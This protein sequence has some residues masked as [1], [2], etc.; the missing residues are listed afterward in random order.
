MVRRD[1][2]TWHRTRAKYFFCQLPNFASLAHDIAASNRYFDEDI[3]I[4]TVNITSRCTLIVP[5]EQNG[6]HYEADEKAIDK[7]MVS[8]EVL[9]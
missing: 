9:K 8:R 3:T 4:P 1:D 7:M 2:R 5:D 6:I